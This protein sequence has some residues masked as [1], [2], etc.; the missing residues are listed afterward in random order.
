[1]QSPQGPPTASLAPRQRP[2]ALPASLAA[3]LRARALRPVLIAPSERRG[4]RR[5]LA[6]AVNGCGHRASRSRLSRAPLLAGEAAGKGGGKRRPAGACAPGSARRRGGVGG[7]VLRQPSWLGRGWGRG[8]KGRDLRWCV[9]PRGGR[10]RRERRLSDGC[11]PGAEVAAGC[12]GRGGGSG[13]AKGLPRPPEAPCRA[14]HGSGVWEELC[15][16]AG[17]RAREGLQRSEGGG[18]PAVRVRR[19]GGPA[20][21]G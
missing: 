16:V 1:M 3:V 17:E 6:A 2:A 4:Q 11:G 15:P 13:S 19:R 5:L 7:V 18:G 10:K 21:R 20:G 9:A 12:R 8:R 14:A